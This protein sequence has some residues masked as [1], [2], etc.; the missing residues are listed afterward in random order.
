MAAEYTLIRDV[1]TNRPLSGVVVF[2]GGFDYVFLD[3]ETPD[4]PTEDDLI[5]RV[6]GGEDREPTPEEVKTAA[7]IPFGWN[8]SDEWISVESRSAANKAIKD[9]LENAKAAFMDPDAEAYSQHMDDTVSEMRVS[10]STYDDV[11][12]EETMD[13]ADFINTLV[14]NIDPNGPDGWRIKHLLD[15]YASTDDD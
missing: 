4:L 6:L 14:N 5:G 13:A 11:S 8:V 9:A 7:L 15:L 12:G 2:N 1:D 10:G 3:G